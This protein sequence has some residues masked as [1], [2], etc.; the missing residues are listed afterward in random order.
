MLDKQKSLE[1][2]EGFQNHYNY[3]TNYMKEMLTENPNAY[4]TFE[5]FLPMA[6]FAD[7]APKDV[8]FV[9]KLTSMKNED[10][11]AC[12][13]LNVD[14]AIEAGVD[15]KIIQDIIFNEGK[16]LTSELKTVYDFT[17]SVGNKKDVGTELYS[18]INALYSKKVLVEIALAIASTKI[19]PTVKRVL[20]DFQTC[21]NIQIKV[22]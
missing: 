14:M 4:E 7:E 5:G 17:L 13:Q 6:S 12:L 15:K 16:T 10:C 19:F 8:L 9:A 21:S 2:L 3:D 20:N 11:G 18:K 1:M 22:K